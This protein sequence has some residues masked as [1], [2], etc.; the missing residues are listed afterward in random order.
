MGAG[1][2]LQQFT[3]S[4]N[5]FELFN[6]P[7]SFK[8][9]RPLL[10]DRWKNLQRSVH[11]DKFSMQD[12]ATQRV[13]MQ[14]SVR[15]N[16]AYQRLKNPLKRASYLCELHGASI[17]AEVN[18][19]MPAEFLLQQMQWR[20][21]LE[22][23]SS[24]SDIGMLQEEVLKAKEAAFLKCENFLDNEKDWLSASEEVRAL[25]FMERFEV[26]I[27]KRQDQLENA[28]QKKH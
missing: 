8:L 2:E 19:H 1:Q 21:K 10:D 22:E 3:L 17:Q 15:V 13:A 7:L 24:I 5:D 9:N 25:M 18:T 23:A 28:E 12:V 27:D 16:E 26:D 6:L 11:P 4:S 14:Y 20:E